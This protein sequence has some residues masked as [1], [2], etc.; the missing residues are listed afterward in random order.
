LLRVVEFPTAGISLQ[1]RYTLAAIGEE[2]VHGN[3]GSDGP[4]RREME[5]P[6]EISESRE[7]EAVALSHVQ[8]PQS[9]GIELA[10]VSN[11]KLNIIAL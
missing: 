6:R 9:D 5:L 11:K 3:A 7:N 10:P 4:D 2:D 8:Q 1:G